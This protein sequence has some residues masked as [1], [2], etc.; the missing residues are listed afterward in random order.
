[1][2]SPCQK[3]ISNANHPYT[4]HSK[5]HWKHWSIFLKEYSTYL[6]P[7]FQNWCRAQ[8]RRWARRRLGRCWTELT[9][10]PSCA[11]RWSS[12]RT[13]PTSWRSTPSS[14]STCPSGGSLGSTTMTSSLEP[15]GEKY[16]QTVIKNLA[17]KLVEKITPPISLVWQKHV[18]PVFGIGTLVGCWTDGEVSVTSRNTYWD[19]CARVLLAGKIKATSESTEVQRVLGLW[20]FGLKLQECSGNTIWSVL[21]WLGPRCLIN[22]QES[23]PV[24]SNGSNSR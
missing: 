11:R 18:L 23:G 19:T 6:T 10:W 14:P 21:I 13:W 4:F 15:P 17:E 22:I 9:S 1:M 5:E 2:S 8:W 12:G 20:Q 3:T 7:L 24:V 16:F